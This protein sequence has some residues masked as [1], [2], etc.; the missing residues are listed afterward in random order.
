MNMRFEVWNVVTDVHTKKDWMITKIHS[1]GLMELIDVKGNTHPF[2]YMKNYR[3]ADSE[4]MEKESMSDITKEY[5]EVKAP[6]KRI[7][8]KRQNSKL[9]AHRRPHGGVTI[10]SD[11][12]YGNRTHHSLSAEETDALMQ[13]LREFRNG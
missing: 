1:D 13:A 4:E 8:I 5:E 7:T 6:L 10:I 12:D 9:E 11:H 3:L 2:V